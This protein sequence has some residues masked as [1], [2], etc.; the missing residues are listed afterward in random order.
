MFL[1]TCGTIFWVETDVS[2]SSYLFGDAISYGY[3]LLK[4]RHL[5]RTDTVDSHRLASL[6][7]V[8]RVHE[9]FL[10]SNFLFLKKV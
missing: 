2:S 4:S 6:E 8:Y 9:L 5:E 1:M 10:K 7:Q 3:I